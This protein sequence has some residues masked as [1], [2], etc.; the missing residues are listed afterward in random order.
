[1]KDRFI[2]KYVRI[3]KSIN[4]KIDIIS[5]EINNPYS[6]QTLEFLLELGIIKYEELKL[7]ESKENEIILKLDKLINLLEEVLNEQS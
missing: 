3:K 4:D 2:K 5:S 7:K 6:Y 1:M